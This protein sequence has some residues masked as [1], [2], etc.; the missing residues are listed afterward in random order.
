MSEYDKIGA[1]AFLEKYGYGKA[2]RYLL[3]SGRKR[4]DS[5]AILGVAYGNQHPDEGPLTAGDFSGGALSVG[6]RLAELG[7]EI[8]EV[9]KS[10]LETPLR[11]PKMR[12]P[13]QF[14]FNFSFHLAGYLF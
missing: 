2:Y 13:G 4:Y 7:F 8:V 14:C 3:K 6:H 11:L 9:Q 12:I 10:G 5:K 1:G